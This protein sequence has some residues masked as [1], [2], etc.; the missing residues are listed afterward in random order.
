MMKKTLA[1]VLALV[2]LCCSGQAL[3][4]GKLTTV[5]ENFWVISSYWADAAYAY[6]RV[7]NTGDKPIDVNAGILE[8]YDAN[9]DVVTSGN[10]L[11]I[12]PKCL[13]PG[14]Y[15]YVALAMEVQQAKDV[16]EP[17]SCKLVI[18]GK[19]DDESSTLR[20]PAQVKTETGEWWKADYM[21]ATVTNNTEETVY[22]IQTVFTLL[23]AEG[24]ILCVENDSQLAPYGLTPGSSVV[25]R[26][27]INKA[28]ISYFAAKDIV[29][30]S[31]DVIAYS[32][33]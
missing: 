9:G 15:T 8:I 12:F 27:E 22:D 16:G 14:E 31:V 1:T 33:R 11:Q 25:V 4:A 3:A 23:D 2:F 20:L 32:N 30:A 10:Y 19:T 17:A 29:P 6:A 18:T 28:F 26:R 5:Q 24:N 7:E 21:T 13:Q